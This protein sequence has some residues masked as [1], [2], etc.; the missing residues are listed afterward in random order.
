MS[1]DTNRAAAIAGRPI[2][3]EATEGAWPLGERK[4][5]EKMFVYV[6]GAK[7]SERKPRYDLIPSVAL[8]RLAARYEMGLKH[9]GEHNWKLGL[10]FDDTL[11][12]LIDHLLSYR[13]RRKAL[14]QSYAEQGKDVPGPFELVEELRASEIDGDDLAA[15]A[16][17]CFTLMA[18]EESGRLQ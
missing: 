18:L 6:T 8:R 14:L 5:E 7:R 3:T 13:D 10:P 11:N 9:Y 12:H 2:T 4:Q 1:A 17:G 15:A 16:W